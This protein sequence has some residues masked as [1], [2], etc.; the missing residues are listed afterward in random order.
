MKKVINS[1]LYNTETAKELGAYSYLS[2][3][4]LY[5][6]SETLYRTK[7]GKYFIYG[8]G[9]P[10]SKYSEM[11]GNNSWSGGEKII[12]ISEDK[13]KEWGEQYLDGDEYIA[14]FGD[15]DADIPDWVS[16]SVPGLTK[17]KIDA[18]RDETKLTL[19]EIVTRAI[20]LYIKSK[21]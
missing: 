13:A 14:A 15:P 7:S 10:A 11:T 3:R 9:G 1:T 16:V 17:V 18:L 19:G 20:D 8:E 4:D 12:P 5:G 21:K 6:W 2:R